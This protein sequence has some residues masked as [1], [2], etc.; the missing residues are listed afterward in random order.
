MLPNIAAIKEL[1]RQQMEMLLIF[2]NLFT[3]LDDL[4]TAEKIYTDLAAREPSLSY[5]LAV[6]LGTHRGADKAF[7]KLNEI[8]QSERNPEKILQAALDIVR[9]KRDEIGDKYDPQIERWLEVGL[10]ENPD[11]I[12]LLIAKADF[13]DI[14]KRYDE[15][16]ATYRKLLPRNDL[17]GIRRAQALNN[18]AFL[19]ALEDSAAADDVDPLKLVKEAADILGP[20]S[21]ILDTRAMVWIARGQ[22]KN[23][24][25]DLE[26]A[27]TDNPTAAKYYHL[28][29]AHLLARENRE[30]VDAWERAEELDLSRDSLNRMEY[31]KYDET[32]AKID[33]IRGGGASVT[34]SDTS[35]KA[36]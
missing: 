35:R 4:D 13:F 19:L 10:L 25:A 17:T 26:L 32:K 1:N 33:Q 23:A 31:E 5:N 7:E 21:D 20:N 2:A 15:S 22:Y 9:T 6:F 34:Q 3:E 28:A 18:L 29:L 14:Q 16:A 27:V 11:S 30:A 8:Y 24:I 12:N 36:G